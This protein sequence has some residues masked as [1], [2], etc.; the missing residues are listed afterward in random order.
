MGTRVITWRPAVAFCA[1]LS[2]M[3]LGAAGADAAVVYRASSQA[4]AAAAHNITVPQPA[5]VQPG[6]VMVATIV[7]GGSRLSLTSAGWTPIRTTDGGPALDQMSFYRVAG[8]AEPASYTFAAA[9]GSD[10]L[11]AGIAAYSGVDAST[12]I[13]AVADAHGPGTA[14]VPSVTTT[15]DGAGVVAAVTTPTS[16]AATMDASIAVR[17]AAGLTKAGLTVG[18]FA[19][20]VAGATGARSFTS[21][22]PGERVAQAIAL[23]PAPAPVADTPTTHTHEAKAS[24]WTLTGGMPLTPELI[25][26]LPRVTTAQSPRVSSA[27]AVPVVV[28]CPVA[29]AAHGCVGTITLSRAPAGAAAA[30]RTK[31]RSRRHFKLAAGKRATVPV[32][33]DRRTFRRFKRKRRAMKLNLRVAVSTSAGQAV[34]VTT[35]T[36]HQRRTPHRRPPRKR[37]R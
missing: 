20:P 14:A 11:V 36:V 13:D 29:A 31:A 18:D 23:R 33:L 3:L 34:K 22:G 5:G 1:A 24:G 7:A 37:R 6:D 21:G 8:A 17:L 15:T 27:G 28:Q 25:A 32:R 10:D 30:R 12:P 4:T 2:A 35:I 19:Q 26:T 9:T 16:T